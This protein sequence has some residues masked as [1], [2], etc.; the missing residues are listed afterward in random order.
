VGVALRYAAS[1]FY[2]VGLRWRDDLYSGTGPFDQRAY[3]IGGQDQRFSVI[4]GLNWQAFP[5]AGSLQPVKDA[6]PVNVKTEP[7]AKLPDD[8]AGKTPPEAP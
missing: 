5:W 1:A 2:S 6:Q 7:P 4:L 3:I 8:D